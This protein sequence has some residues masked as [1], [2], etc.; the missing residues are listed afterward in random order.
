MRKVFCP[1]LGYKMILPKNIAKLNYGAPAKMNFYQKCKILWQCYHRATPNKDTLFLQ[2]TK[3]VF[4]KL[5]LSSGT[6]HAGGPPPR[7]QKTEK[8]GSAKLR[9]FYTNNNSTIPILYTINGT[10]LYLIYTVEP[11]WQNLA[12]ATPEISILRPK[13]SF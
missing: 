1:I 13:S 3:P 6:F 9:P 2:I 4:L 11:Y 7:S 5:F 10:L 8:L 12:I